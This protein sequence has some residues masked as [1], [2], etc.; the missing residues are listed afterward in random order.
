MK[1]LRLSPARLWAACLMF[2]PVSLYGQIAGARIDGK[3]LS[4]T[5]LPVPNAKVSYYRAPRLVKDQRGRWV[6]AVNEPYVSSNA[7]SASDGRFGIS[8][9]PDGVYSLCIDA[10]G[11]LPT[12]GWSG[13]V[14]LTVSAKVAV[15][16][17]DVR[18]TRAALLTFRVSDPGRLLPSEDRM[19]RP[20]VV[21]V[22]N[23]YGTFYAAERV[24]SAGA[25][26]TFELRIP[27][28]RQ[29]QIWVQSWK[30]K[31][32]GA[33]GGVIDSKGARIPLRVEQGTASKA[34][35]ITISG[36]IGK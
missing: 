6:I 18:L 7:A 9:L 20:L 34:F 4:D 17:P 3:I 12:C 30:F 15:V 11:Y 25:G 16:V 36:E 19:N 29:L 5:G 21:G 14:N 27:Y 10:A 13:P 8:G 23:E 31:L 24:A 28:S 2:W 22:M 35:D 1:L 32:A 33:D 26:A